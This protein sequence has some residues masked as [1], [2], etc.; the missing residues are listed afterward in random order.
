[1]TDTQKLPNPEFSRK[2]NLGDISEKQPLVKSFT[3][4]PEECEKLAKRFDLIEL[5]N[6]EADV[7]FTRKMAGRMAEVTG[8]FTVDVVQRC[9]ITLDPVPDHIEAE[10][11][12]FFTDIKPPTPI[13]GEVEMPPEE[14]AP[15]YVAGGAIDAG[16]VVAQYIALELD[17]YPRKD[18]AQHD[19]TDADMPPEEE[20]T[21]RPFA[22]LAQLKKDNQ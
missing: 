3:A 4:K 17:P 8:R 10:F 21:H 6:L 15:E 9:I 13:A 14:D 19:I 1:M 11:E 18:G 12:A 5:K 7:T 22:A 2:V 16:E 20:K